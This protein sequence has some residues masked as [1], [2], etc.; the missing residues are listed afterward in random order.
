MNRWAGLAAG[1][2]LTAGASAPAMAQEPPEGFVWYVLRELND[3][4]F[5]IDD[6]TN[7]PPLITEAPAG[8][9]VAV[10]ANGDNRTDWL[11]RWPEAMQVCGTGGCRVT[12]YR[13]GRRVRSRVRPSGP[14]VRYPHRGRRAASRGGAASADMR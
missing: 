8:V 14:V 5:D 13:D 7:R 10:D 4:G 6:P 12:L 11:I 2:M 9:L 3:F 1:L